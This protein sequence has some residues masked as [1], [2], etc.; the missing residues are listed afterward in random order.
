MGVNAGKANAGAISFSTEV[1]SSSSNK[2]T[3]IVLAIEHLGSTGVFDGTG[4]ALAKR[5]IKVAAEKNRKIVLRALDDN[6]KAFWTK[7]GFQSETINNVLS[8]SMEMSLDKV[9]EEAS[10]D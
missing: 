7:V 1:S 6:A 8:R 2:P 10:I 3:E 5:V 9:K 4:S